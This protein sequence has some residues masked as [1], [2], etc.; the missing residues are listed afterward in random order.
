[1]ENWLLSLPTYLISLTKL[2]YVESKGSNRYKCAVFI[3][4]QAIF[5]LLCLTLLHGLR[6]KSIAL[7]TLPQLPFA[8]VS[9]EIAEQAAAI[10]VHHTLLLL[11]ISSFLYTTSLLVV[12]ISFW[13]CNILIK[14]FFSFVEIKLEDDTRR[15]CKLCFTK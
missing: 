8:P 9:I 12:E 7:S 5:T 15:G 13:P 1:M 4:W 3:R 10:N 11:I 6:A 14:E 2:P